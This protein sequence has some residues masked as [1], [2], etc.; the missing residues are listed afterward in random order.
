MPSVGVVEARS[1]DRAEAYAA[2]QAPVP[3]HSVAAGSLDTVMAKWRN[4]FRSMVVTWLR[5][6]TEVVHGTCAVVSRERRRRE[7]LPLPRR[8][9]FRFVVI[10][11]SQ[12]AADQ[13]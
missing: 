8:N 5:Q 13:M 2:T 10:T 7:P 6:R 9:N 4:Y 1:V 11:W 12:A 3:A